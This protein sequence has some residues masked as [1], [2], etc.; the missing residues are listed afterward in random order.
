VI[1]TAGREILTS[2]ES[3]EWKAGKCYG[4]YKVQT[5]SCPKT[6]GGGASWH[7]RTSVHT[8]QDVKFEEMWDALA[9][10]KA[11]KEME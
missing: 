5:S 10:D 7:C 2:T 1:I 6:S 9:N 3:K 8:A 11:I 4:K